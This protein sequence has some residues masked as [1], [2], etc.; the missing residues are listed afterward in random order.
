MSQTAPTFACLSC[1]SL[2]V[3]FVR[4][5]PPRPYTQTFRTPQGSIHK[6]RVEPAQAVF[7]CNRCRIESPFTVPDDWRHDGEK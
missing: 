1:R 2:F 5:I 3:E 6:Q 4:R 7:W